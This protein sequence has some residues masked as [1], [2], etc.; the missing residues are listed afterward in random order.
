M[1]CEWHNASVKLASQNLRRVTHSWDQGEN[2]EEGHS[3]S[4]Y[5]IEIYNSS[6][7]VLELALGHHMALI[8]DEADTRA[9]STRQM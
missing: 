2:W 3:R 7:E 9:D 5:C 6:V 4:N 1:I 8:L